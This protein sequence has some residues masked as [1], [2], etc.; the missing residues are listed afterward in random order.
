[1]IENLIKQKK[2]ES[3]IVTLTKKRI[4]NNLNM[5][6]MFTGKLGS[7]KS[8]SGISYALELDPDFDA[9][10]QI[11]FNF[12]KTMELINA[13]W[14]QKKKVKVILWDEPQITIS[15]RAWQSQ[16][17]K[18]VNYLISTF[19]HQNII[20]IMAAP[21]KDF[22]DSQTMKLLHWEFQCSKINKKKGVC[23]TYPKYQQYNPNKKITY[24]HPLYVL[25]KGKRLLMRTWKIKKPNKE[26]IKIYETN[27]LKF[28]AS[29]NKD[30][31]KKL[32][33]LEKVEDKP[34]SILDTGTT[35]QREAKRLFVEKGGNIDEVAKELGITERS[36]Y[37]RIGNKDNLADLRAIDPNTLG[38]V[39]FEPK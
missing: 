23:I 35:K 18:L 8:W 15:N 37:Q 39:G 19:R 17:N 25:T 34:R 14:F 12:R 24:P 27:K 7:G 1:M 31:E 9:E 36:T 5:F 29:L 32:N 10:K 26:A 13:D 20:L 38:N 21:Y 33:E 22:L 16:V 4:K 2:G 30:I 6:C 28:T 11:T 3:C